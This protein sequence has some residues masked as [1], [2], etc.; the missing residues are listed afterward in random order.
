MGKNTKR[1]PPFDMAPK[2]PSELEQRLTNVKNSIFRIVYPIPPWLCSTIFVSSLAHQ[3]I[4][5][6]PASLFSLDTLHSLY[7]STVSTLAPVVLAKLYLYGFVFRYKAW[8][9]ENPK[10][11]SLFTKIWGF[12]FHLLK[13]LNPPKLNTCNHLLPKQPVPE[14]R[15]TVNGYLES[16]KPIVDKSEYDEIKA[17]ADY[18]LAKE[19]PHLQNYANFLSWTRRNY[20]SEFWE[21]YVYLAN[22]EPLSINSS[23]GYGDG[24]RPKKCSMARRGAHHLH[25][26]ILNVIAIHKEQIRPTADGLCYT[27]WHNRIFTYN[28]V[29]GKHVDRFLDHGLTRHVI[30]LYNGCMYKVDVFDPKTNKVYTVA[31]LEAIFED[32]IARND[33]PSEV[34]SK[35][36][37]LTHDYRDKWAENRERFFLKDPANYECLRDAETALL[38]MTLDP[39][40]YGDVDDDPDATSEYMKVMT[41]GKG[42]DRWMDKPFNYHVTGCGRLGGTLEHAVCDGAEYRTVC[43]NILHCEGE[44]LFKDDA[45]FPEYKKH[46]IKYAERMKVKELPGMLE[47]VNRCYDMTVERTKD[48]DLASILFRDFG[49]EQIKKLKCSPDGFMQMA[50]Q[51]A[52]YRA[53]QKFVPTYEAASSHFFDYSRT[54]TLRTVGTESCDFVEAVIN[55]EDICERKKKLVAACEA[56]TMKNKRIMVGKGVDRHLFVLYVLSKYKGMTSDFLETYIG[57]KWTLSTTQP[58]NVTG[59]CR[60]D[61]VP[62]ESWMGGAFG[63]V[64]KNGYGIVYKFLGSHSIG[65]HVSS[66]HS[67][68]STDSKMMR[69]L[70]LDALKEMVGYFG[71]SQ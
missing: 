16:I 65:L 9:F 31:E 46:T 55:N 1:S 41:C 57:Q 48:M 24:Q 64:D 40:E 14:L 53:H 20:I 47:E 2:F 34:E 10:K 29:P 28:R 13:K 3:L 44:Y 18:F 59:L 22:R 42:N 8:L 71:E 66:Y 5:T 62:V 50:I 32:I 60:E 15:N 54:E 43:E 49:K 36:T 56:H 23:V 6:Q 27:E 67:S 51:L 68:P 12:S 69:T 30:I 52:Y 37:S 19:G 58:P 63:A 21:K 25:L 35:V 26:L 11:P 39:T 7:I 38:S 61:T 17:K 4:K 33:V 70:I 45:K